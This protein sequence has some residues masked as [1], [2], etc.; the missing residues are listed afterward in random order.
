[1]GSV[2]LVLSGTGPFMALRAP[3]RVIQVKGLTHRRASPATRPEL[4]G[5]PDDGEPNPRE[6]EAP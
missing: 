4:A 5:L 6:R 1:M 2:T 3:S